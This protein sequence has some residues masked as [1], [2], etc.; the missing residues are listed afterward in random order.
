MSGHADDGERGIYWLYASLISVQL[1]L[2]VTT[3]AVVID[4][5]LGVVA[6]RQAMANW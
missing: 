1:R 5:V 4:K 3:K 2:S 6:L